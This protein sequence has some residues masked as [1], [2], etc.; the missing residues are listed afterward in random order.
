M[1]RLILTWIIL[2]NST[3]CTTTTWVRYHDGLKETETFRHYPKRSTSYNKKGKIV[4]LDSITGQLVNI[5]K[6][7]KKITDVG[8][9][10]KKDI[11]ITYDSTGKRISRENLLR[12]KLKNGEQNIKTKF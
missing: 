11:L 6:Y 8:T 10:N 4:Y 5:E 3:A 2:F 7:I 12:V 1:K 9:K